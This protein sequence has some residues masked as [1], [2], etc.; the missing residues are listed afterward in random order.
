MAEP[1]TVALAKSH[2]GIEASFTADDTIITSYTI[3]ARQLVELMAG[4]VLLVPATVAEYHDAFGD[5]LTLYKGPIAA[6]AEVTI[7]Y[8]DEGEAEQD[9]EG[10]VTRLGRVPARIYPAANGTFPTLSANGGVTV[11]YTAGFPDGEVPQRY[12]QAILLL[13][14]H[15]YRNRMPVSVA[16]NLPQELQF[17]V[18][19]LIN[20]QPVL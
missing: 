19:A 8:V 12:I 1:V 14:A 13:T 7:A 6:D 15:F 9:Y 3:A 4:D 17:A 20:K 11:T 10:F 18:T 16:S 2:L 5:F